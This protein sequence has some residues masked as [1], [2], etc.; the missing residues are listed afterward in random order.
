[1]PHRGC[2][3]VSHRVSPFGVLGWRPA[4]SNHKRGR[5]RRSTDAFLVENAST[6]GV[7]RPRAPEAFPSLLRVPYGE[8]LLVLLC[9]FSRHVGE[10]RREG[11]DREGETWAPKMR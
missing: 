7:G 5:E 2:L 1:M 8:F 3:R 10:W 11:G 4:N 9:Q 6:F